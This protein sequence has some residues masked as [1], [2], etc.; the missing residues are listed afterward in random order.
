[1]LDLCASDVVLEGAVDEDLPLDVYEHH[2]TQHLNYHT[3]IQI[4]SLI[5]IT[6]HRDYHSDSEE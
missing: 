4:R 6:T 3:W 1:V 2:G 5:I